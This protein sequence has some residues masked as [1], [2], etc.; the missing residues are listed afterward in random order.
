MEGADYKLVKN[1]VVKGLMSDQQWLRPFPFLVPANRKHS[2]WLVRT[3]PQ[4][5][6]L[7]QCQH[8]SILEWSEEG[9]SLG[10][11]KPDALKRLAFLAQNLWWLS[12]FLMFFFLLLISFGVSLEQTCARDLAIVLHP[13]QAGLKPTASEIYETTELTT[14]LQHHHL[15]PSVSETHISIGAF[16]RRVTL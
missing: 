15:Q 4:F 9:G 14:K 5:L 6:L 12:L 2:F 1:T 10:P 7:S 16:H 8:P 13:V 11:L 3:W